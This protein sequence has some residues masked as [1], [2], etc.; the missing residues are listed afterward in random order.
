MKKIIFTNKAPAAIGPYSQA[1]RKGPGIFLSG[2]LGVD[3]ATGELVSDDVQEQTRQALN[4]ML[5]V[6]DEAHATIEDVVKVTVFI[7][8]MADF[9]AINEIY[10]SVFPANPPARTCV[11]VAA[12]PK[13]GKI[14]IEALAFI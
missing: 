2:Q 4:N 11:Q 8:D 14:E 3:P 12:L 9:Q 5:A 7:T 1:T 10:A 6:L 13:G